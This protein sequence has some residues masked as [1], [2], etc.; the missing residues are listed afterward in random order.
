MF[1]AAALV[2]SWALAR[3]M[4]ATAVAA[5]FRHYGQE[6]RDLDPGRYPE[7]RPAALERIQYLTIRRARE[8]RE[9]GSPIQKAFGTT[10]IPPIPVPQS[11]SLSSLETQLRR[12]KAQLSSIARGLEQL[13][14]K[15]A[16]APAAAVPGAAP[17]RAPQ[18]SNVPG[19]PQAQLPVA[20]FRPYDAGYRLAGA[21]GKPLLVW[22][23]YKCP[24]SANQVPG[25]VHVQASQMNGSRAQRVIV[26]VP[27]GKGGF[28]SMGTVPA[29]AVCAQNLQA[30][31]PVAQR[32][33]AA[34]GT[35]GHGC[36]T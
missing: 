14:I 34:R 16:A 12:I 2:V 1:P 24:S 5:A 3:D 31:L 21:Q 20:M 6:A 11:L 4:P 27:D 13:Q 33:T 10:S 32:A 18:T 26:G 15:P 28:R 30:L 36:P 25:A 17:A 23:Q 9:D 7:D 22:V 35:A 19:A 29:A 8:G